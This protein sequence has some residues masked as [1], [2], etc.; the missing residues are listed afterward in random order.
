MTTCD[1]SLTGF[2]TTHCKLG[3]SMVVAE[4][5]DGSAAVHTIKYCLDSELTLENVDCIYH[6]LPIIKNNN[7]KNTAS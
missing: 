7:Y 1:G 2:N 5:L 4:V 6:N 3:A